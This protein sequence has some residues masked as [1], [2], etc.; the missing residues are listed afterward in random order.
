M[1]KYI[2]AE[3]SDQVMRPEIARYEIE[4]IAEETAQ[5][6]VQAVQ[7]RLVEIPIRYN[8]TE[9]EWQVIWMTSRGSRITQRE[10]E[11][12]RLR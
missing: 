1:T 10:I 12:T 2:E 7:D 4:A 8:L 5:V 3:F 6:Y 9:E 11:T